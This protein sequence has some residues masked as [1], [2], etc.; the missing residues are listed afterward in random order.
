MIL[1]FA[2]LADNLDLVTG[3]WVKLLGKLLIFKAVINLYVKERA[4]IKL[5]DSYR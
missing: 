2:S 3:I 5:M 1:G 4:E